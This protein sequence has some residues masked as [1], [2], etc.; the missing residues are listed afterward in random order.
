MVW[1]KELPDD[2]A[3]V[4]LLLCCPTSSTKS[5]G[6]FLS[7]TGEHF[8]PDTDLYDLERFCSQA[9]LTTCHLL[10]QTQDR[11]KISSRAKVIFA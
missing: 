1:S 7:E 2:T 9:S 3:Q 5:Q 11:V 4:S 10:S 6:R 8:H